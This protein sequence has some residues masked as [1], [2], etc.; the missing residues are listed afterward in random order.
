MVVAKVRIKPLA[1]ILLLHGENQLLDIKLEKRTK[2]AI[3]LLLKEERNKFTRIFM[4]GNNVQVSKKRAI[5]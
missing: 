1:E 3:N 4:G 2:Q 5:C